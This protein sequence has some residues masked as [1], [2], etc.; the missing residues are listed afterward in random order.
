MMSLPGFSTQKFHFIVR[1]EGEMIPNSERQPKQAAAW[2]VHD[3]KD[4]LV[5]T[6]LTLADHSILFSPASCVL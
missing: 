4:N 3:R 6:S 2:Q 1:E 5:L